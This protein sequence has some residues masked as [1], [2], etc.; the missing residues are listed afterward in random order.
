[1][2]SDM[3]KPPRA[4]LPKGWAPDA[5]DLEKA[6]QLLDLPRKI[7]P[8]PEDGQMIEAGI[9]RFGP[10]VKH[11]ST[12]ANLREVDEVF[13]I[14]INRAVDAIAQKAARGAARGA[15]AK[16]LKELG[17]HPD[18][19]AIQVLDGRYGPYV[20]WEKVNAT[21]PK[22]T[23][24]ESVTMEQALEWIT[25]KAGAKGKKKAAPKKAAAKAPAKKASAKKPA[26]KKAAPKKAAAKKTA[27]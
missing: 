13:T 24:P 18:G 8:H 11:G 4:S 15:A 2:S 10:Y 1:A 17:D 19:G 6:R 26:A 22:G 3:P 20:K 21:I 25:A 12:Y 16:P 9:G 5:M 23:D 27:E 7:G 14:G